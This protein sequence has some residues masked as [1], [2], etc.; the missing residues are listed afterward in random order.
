MAKRPK[1]VSQMTVAQFDALFPAGDEAAEEP[2]AEGIYA[3]HDVRAMPDV[4]EYGAVGGAGS[5]GVRRDH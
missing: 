5:R 4:H 1:P 2:F 3:V